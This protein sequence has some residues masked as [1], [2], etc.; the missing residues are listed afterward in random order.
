MG[1]DK[2]IKNKGDTHYKIEHCCVMANIII[3][4]VDITER[5][6][7]LLYCLVTQ[8]K[9]WPAIMI[10]DVAQEEDLYHLETASSSCV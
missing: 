8:D 9:L 1:G 10:R 7:L 4:L 6:H 5:G 2:W 3:N